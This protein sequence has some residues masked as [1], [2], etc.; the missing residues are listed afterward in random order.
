MDNVNKRVRRCAVTLAEVRDS[1]VFEDLL[2]TH[3]SNANVW[4]DSA[5]RAKD[6]QEGSRRTATAVISPP[7]EN[8]KS[9]YRP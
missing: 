4:A 9:R 5:Y 3:N 8:A 6:N 7:R 1:Q 2:D